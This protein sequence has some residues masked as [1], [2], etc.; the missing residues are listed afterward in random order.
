MIIFP[1]DII[2]L[3]IYPES[4]LMGCPEMRLFVGIQLTFKIRKIREKGPPRAPRGWD[5]SNVIYK[6]NHLTLVIY[7]EYIA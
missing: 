5:D 6:K 3:L 4:S 1:S 7:K 2:Y